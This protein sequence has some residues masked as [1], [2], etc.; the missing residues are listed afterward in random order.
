M[1]FNIF[2]IIYFNENQKIN[3]K[4]IDNINFKFY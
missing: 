1:P 3:K 2:F 4:Y